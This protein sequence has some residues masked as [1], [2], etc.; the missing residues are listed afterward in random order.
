MP[1]PT[2]PRKAL[3]VR[4]A[5]QLA[6]GTLVDGYKVV[7]PE[8]SKYEEYFELAV[9]DSTYG[10]PMPYAPEEQGCICEHGGLP[11]HVKKRIERSHGE[12]VSVLEAA[13]EKSSPNQQWSIE[14]IDVALAVE[15]H[16]WFWRPSTVRVLLIAESHVYTSG[17][18]L[19]L[20]LQYEQIPKLIN[21]PRKFVRLVYCLGYGEPTLLPVRATPQ[22]RQGGTPQFWD[23]FA[24][25]AGT[26]NKKPTASSRD[27]RV[28]WKMETLNA[29]CNRGIWLLDASVHA[30]YA[31]TGNRRQDG[32]VLRR[33]NRISYETASDLHHS[34][35]QHYGEPT[36][37][38][39]GN[40]PIWFIGKSVHDI[41][42][43]KNQQLQAK[44]WMYQ[45]N[46]RPRK[47]LQPAHFLSDLAASIEAYLDGQ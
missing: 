47:R 40:P 45:P 25:L 16:R 30:I 2:Y 35:W 22:Q 15:E 9:R 27:E 20:D 1:D 23:I 43:S 34:W 32:E 14:P 24:T 31:P 4:T 18:D 29:L 11:D 44:G 19:A 21:A 12:G 39:L 38:E 28:L 41:L 3:L 6:D 36:I 33:S 8:D 7:K 46:A 42:K 17:E 10:I 37:H 26:K 13:N 5:D